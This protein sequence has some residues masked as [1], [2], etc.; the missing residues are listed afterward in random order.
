MFEVKEGR[1]S[2]AILPQCQ[3]QGTLK[4]VPEPVGVSALG[5]ERPFG[6]IETSPN[7]QLLVIMLEGRNTIDPVG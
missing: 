4:A 7:V 2:D 5:L 1:A 6:Y 3:G